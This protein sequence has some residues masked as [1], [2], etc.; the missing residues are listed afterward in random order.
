MK[1]FIELLIGVVMLAC[2]FRLSPVFPDTHP[3]AA[4]F[5]FVFACASFR[6]GVVLTTEG[7]RKRRSRK[8]RRRMTE[9]GF[10]TQAEMIEAKK[11]EGR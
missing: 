10:P 2:A 9:W 1:R 4:G 7:S 3:I 5:S 8:W 6:G 11:A